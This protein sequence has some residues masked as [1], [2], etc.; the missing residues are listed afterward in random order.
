MELKPDINRPG[1]GHFPPQFVHVTNQSVH[2]KYLF[3]VQRLPHNVEH[4][5]NC[6]ATPMSFTTKAEGDLIKALLAMASIR[7]RSKQTS[8][9]KLNMYKHISSYHSYSNIPKKTPER[10]YL[11]WKLGMFL[12]RRPHFTCCCLERHRGV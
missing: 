8:E 5:F 7:R 9:I 3:S 1:G 6:S 12:M 10:T 11:W 2:P 4:T